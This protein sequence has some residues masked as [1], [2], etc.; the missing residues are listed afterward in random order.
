MH[1]ALGVITKPGGLTVSESLVSH[2][3]IVVI[4]PI[5]GQ[6]EENAE[7][8]VK[9]NVAIWIKKGDNIARALKEL[10][11]DTEK[12]KLMAKN[13]E[14]LAKPNA[15]TNICETLIN[16]FEDINRIPNKLIVSIL[17]KCKDKYL[18]IEQNKNDSAYPDSLHIVGG[19]IEDNETPEQAIKREVLEEVNIELD[20]VTPYD[21]D[22]DI[23]MYKGKLTQLI[24]LR[25][26]AE[27]KEICGSPASDAKKILWLDKKEILNYK[28][29]EPSI[30]L[31]KKLNII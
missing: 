26:T 12:M 28:H 3:P 1:I 10:S 30:R 8:L 16:E 31:L 25:Y 18:F 15:T 7:F 23:L 20:K 2:L 6:E 19:G 13:A 9:N 11:R 21:F 24:F 5:P 4:N 27:I 29:T 14:S 17:I 22:S